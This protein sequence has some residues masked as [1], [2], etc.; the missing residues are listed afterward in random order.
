MRTAL[1]GDIAGARELYRQAAG[2]IRR[3]G[4]RQ[5]AAGVSTLGGASLLIM[6]DRTAEI[7]GDSSADSG[8]PAAFPE[9]YALGLAASGH[10]AQAREVAALARPDRRDNRWLFHAAVRGLLAIAIDDRERAGS[11]YQALLPF[12]GRP[13]GADG[14]LITLSP[15]AQILGD[16]ARYLGRPEAEAHYRHALA[17][18][19]RAQA[20]PWREA[21]TR[22][23]REGRRSTAAAPRQPATGPSH[24]H[25]SHS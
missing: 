15:V 20:A 9:V 25:P 10:V 16:L 4:E 12:A 6:Q 1:D 5:V 2:H 23:L 13:A 17:I 14:M 21:A 3:L 18:A 11:A 8:M 7:A 22:R 24:M 19:E